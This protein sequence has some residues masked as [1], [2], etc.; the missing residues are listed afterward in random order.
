MI[1]TPAP[2]SRPTPA[3]QLRAPENSFPTISNASRKSATGNSVFHP[4]P[5]ILPHNPPRELQRKS[6][7]HAMTRA[8]DRTYGVGSPS[9]PWLWPGQMLC[10]LVELVLHVI[11]K[12]RMDAVRPV[13]G[14][15]HTST[16][17]AVL[18]AMS[19]GT[20]DE[21][22]MICAARSGDHP[23][24]P[25]A[26]SPSCALTLSTAHSGE[27]RNPVRLMRQEQAFSGK[28]CDHALPAS[29]RKTVPGFRLSPE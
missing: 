17:P 18:P 10:A 14:E 6:K 25:Q 26:H 9:P 12:F 15:C 13:R 23:I 11:R 24:H 4:A 1:A 21:K 2:Q 28:H 8:Q 20:P 27:S 16:P 3:G 29:P 22:E 19:D 5:S 7:H